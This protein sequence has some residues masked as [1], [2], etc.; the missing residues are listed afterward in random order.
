MELTGTVIDFLPE[1]SGQGKNGTWRKQ[2]FILEIPG[3]YSKKVCVALWG[4][5]I[6]Q[7]GLQLNDSITAS[8]E[9]ESREYNSRW[10]TEVKA[11]KIARNGYNYQQN[12]ALDEQPPVADFPD[13][14]DSDD[15][16]F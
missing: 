2:E 14:D 1:V 15:L 9:V 4:D 5:K 7:S 10:Y 11:W 3:Q 12:P 8:I 6:D 13:A 16:P